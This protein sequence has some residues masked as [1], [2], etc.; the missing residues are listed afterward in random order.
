VCR[1]VPKP[2]E[3]ISS[4]KAARTKT[5]RACPK[6]KKA[7]WRWRAD[8]GKKRPR[9][10]NGLRADCT[11][12]VGSSF[13]TCYMKNNHDDFGSVVTTDNCTSSNHWKSNCDSLKTHR[14]LQKKL[15]KK[16]VSGHFSQKAALFTPD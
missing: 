14:P 12:A 4:G 11:W 15:T 2:F 6:G 10:Q 3:S 1:N 16:P 5:C 7:E 8:C 9:A 13:P